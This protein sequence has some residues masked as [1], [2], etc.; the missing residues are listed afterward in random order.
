MLHAGGCN[1]LCNILH[2]LAHGCWL[3]VEETLFQQQLQN[4]EKEPKV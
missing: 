4:I 1:T 3:S 2:S